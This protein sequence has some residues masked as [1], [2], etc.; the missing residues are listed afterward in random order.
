MSAPTF[1]EVFDAASQPDVPA[2]KKVRKAKEPKPPKEPKRKRM[3]RVSKQDVADSIRS[4]A[5]MLTV[6]R[7]EITPVLTLAQQYEGTKLGAAY[8]HVAD[9][10]IAGVPFAEA[11]AAEELFPPVVRR[12]VLVGQ[13]TGNPGPHLTKAAD[14]LDETLETSGKVKSALLEPS[15]LG[16]GVVVFF[17][18][19][20]TWA[21]PQM[22]D[23]FA[24]TGAELPMLSQIALQIS[25]VAQVVVPVLAVV[26]L[27]AFVWWRVA[28]RKSDVL[29]ARLDAWQ[30]RLPVL[31]VLKRD[32]ALSNSLSVLSALIDLGIPEREALSTAAEGCDNR[33]IGAHLR[34]H[35]DALVQGRAQFADLAD[36][37]LIPLPVGAVLSAAASSGALPVGLTHVADT[38][39]RSARIK[40]DNLS[41]ALGPI[42]NVVVGALFAG[43]V[44]VIYLPMYSMFTA[45]TSF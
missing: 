21:V 9:Q 33:A 27:S 2:D 42:A 14:L 35:A 17:V 16:V 40:A 25:K 15:M 3:G 6:Q 5:M 11:L 38:Y 26:G 7:G 13:R 45:M 43:A 23:V 20:V 36:G 4:L 10:I 28:G 44:I 8:Q 34:S 19:M 39:R 41:T 18:G 12:L 37:R 1:D 32:A 30:L 22:V 29:R 31:G 24:Q